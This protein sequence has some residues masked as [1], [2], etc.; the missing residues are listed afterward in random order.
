M[1]DGG[2]D[3][4]FIDHQNHNVYFI[5]SKFRTSEKNFETKDISVKEILC[6]DI[7]NI[8]DGIGFDEEGNEYNGKIKQLLRDLSEV[9]EIGR[10]SY[11]VVILANLKDFKKS[12][13]KKL[14]NG[15]P[16]EVYNNDKV[17][18]NLLFP[19]VT[20]TYYSNDLLSITLNLSNM[21]SPSS[22]VSYNVQTEYKNC[23][24]T[25]VFVPTREIG[26]ILHMY[27]NSILKFNPR[28]FLEM[29]GN[30]V[31]KE[32]Y[33]TII[34]KKTNEF[35]LFNNGI[36]M[37]SDTTDFNER[38]G[39]KDK[40][41][42]LISN[43][44]II[45]GGQTAFTLS[46]IYEEIQNG[47][48]K[49][50]IFENKEVLLKIITFGDDVGKDESKKK[51]LIEN[52]SKATNR[53]SEVSDADR[54]S[55]DKIQ[56]ELQE[57]IFDNY[58]YYYERKK[59]EFADGIKDKYI[60]RQQIIDR[61]LFLRLAV[62]CDNKP[63]LARRSSSK[64]LFEEDRFTTH[65]N[66]ISRTDEYMYAY[67]VYQYISSVE[68]STKRDKNDEYGVSAYGQSLRYGKYA[69]VTVSVHKFFKDLNSFDTLKESVDEIL[70]EWIAFEKFALSLSTNTQYFKTYEDEDTGGTIQDLNYAGYYKGRT[71]NEDLIQYFQI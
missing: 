23:D 10:Y 20:G 42:V 1:K 71:I 24:I 63:S 19:V 11:K 5:Q 52:I 27:K 2:I 16:V 33:S 9:S 44:Q 47:D 6:M 59:G 18:Q 22:R 37:L 7:D 43:P 69:L 46:R 67:K 49:P 50:D 3:A 61:E 58:G 14:V 40:A 28:C 21:N 35:A 66:D 34:D 68:K 36:T 41:Q 62:A 4:Y 51:I 48:V 17:Y 31:N 65:L 32:I 70:A 60:T 64:F 26:R 8:V 38:I 56:V 53:Q 57:L 54:R 39:Q 45:N 13:L 55:N 29:K 15:F 12:E 25:V 30:S